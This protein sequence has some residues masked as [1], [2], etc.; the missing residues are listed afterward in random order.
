MQYTSAS[1]NNRKA[2]LLL[3]SG[4]VLAAE[5]CFRNNYTRTPSVMTCANY[6]NF[7]LDEHNQRSASLIANFELAIRRI[8]A[9]RL[10]R[11]ASKHSNNKIASYHMFCL[12]GQY[13]IISRNRCKAKMYFDKAY[14]INRHSIEA[15]S[16]LA[17]ISFV[18]RRYIDLRSQLAA[19]RELLQLG[20]DISS[21]LEIIFDK[22]PF[23]MFPYYQL[24]V[25]A[26]ISTG[27]YIHACDLFDR[28]Y[29]SSFSCND[30]QFPSCHLFLLALQLDKYE[31]LPHLFTLVLNSPL[32]TQDQINF[33]YY[34]LKKAGL[35]DQLD[36]LQTCKLKNR[37]SVHSKVLFHFRIHAM[38]YVQLLSPRGSFSGK[39]WHKF[40]G[41]RIVSCCK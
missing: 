30:F 33:L 29:A 40:A 25:I 28:M 18:E 15:L 10:L 13:Y 8:R 22:C 39:E 11:K 19:L 31:L 35:A 1:M 24:S 41:R 5:T 2:I 32:A 38:N 36:E 4:D 34:Q 20:D 37:T 12:L 14:K 9:K 16:A 17:W 21:N 6:A 27:D 3:D 26:Y 7:L 23:T